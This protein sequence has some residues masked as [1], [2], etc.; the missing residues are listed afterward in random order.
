M[1]YQMLEQQY[2]QLQQQGQNN[3]QTLQQLAGRIRALAPDDLAARELTMDLRGLAMSLQQQNQSIA[4]M[5][6][7]MAQRLQQMEMQMQSMGQGGMNPGMQQRPWGNP[8]G[9]GMGS[10]LMGSVVTGLGL[11]AGF[12]VADNIVNDIFDAF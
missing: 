8:A 2:N 6:Q 10:G 3:I 9:P 12:A 4:L 5:M 1:D 7:Q 11:G